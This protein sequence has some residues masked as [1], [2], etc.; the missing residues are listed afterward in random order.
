MWRTL[1]PFTLGAESNVFGGG[2]LLSKWLRAMS[3]AIKKGREME[4]RRERMKEKRGTVPGTKKARETMT[5]MG[6]WSL[7]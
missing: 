2:R 3:R 1:N 5:V 4:T 6:R 7:T